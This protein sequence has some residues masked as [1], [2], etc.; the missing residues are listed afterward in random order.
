[1]AAQQLAADATEHRHI[2]GADLEGVLDVAVIGAGFGGLGAGVALQRAGIHRFEILEAADAVGGTWRDNTYPG[3]ACDI[4]SHLYSFS[5][6]QNP[7]WSRSYPAQP[8]IEAYLGHTT[9]AFGL[10]PSIR[11]GCE[12]AEL[13]WDDE[14][15]LWRVLLA[16]GTEILSRSV[17][18]ATGGL[19]RPS[20]PDIEGL[21]RFGGTVF[22]SA[23]WNHGHDLTGERVGVIGTGASAI[24]LVPEVAP[25]AARTTV[26]QRTAPWVLPRDDRP[27]PMW[28]R[29]LYARVPML[30]RLHRWRVYARQEMLAVAF[31]GR[32]RARAAVSARIAEAGREH[33]AEHISDPELRERLTPTYEPGCKRLLIAND[34]YPALARDDVEVVSS[35]ITEVVPEGVRTADGTVHHLDT[36]VLATGFTATEFLAPMR[37]V[38]RGGLE[39]DEHW[40]DGAAT[41]LG[42]AV[43]GF[44]NLFLLVGPGTTLGHNSIVFMIESQ[45]RWVMGALGESRRRG[46]ALELRPDIERREYAAQQRRAERTVWASGCDSWYRS[47]DGRLDT[48]WP[49]TTIEYWWRTRRFDPAMLRPVTPT[50]PA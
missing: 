47:S 36:L 42:I 28:R 19:S 13:R 43:S 9:D 10:R 1:M 14:R 3:C 7:A 44:P 15:A 49:G 32:G 29:R 4:P 48:V 24:Q 45:L 26:F 39:L 23:R 25:V 50:P 21:D 34:W 35:A 5:F 46:T 40:R 41:H 16:D 17:I 22:H 11:F 2:P 31:V 30:Q 38:G 37:V 6:A 12:V 33:I 20:L 18:S 27:A 8:E